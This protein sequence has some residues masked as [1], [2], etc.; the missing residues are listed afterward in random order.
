MKYLSVIL[1]LVAALTLRAEDKSYIYRMSVTN[2][3]G[4]TQEDTLVF[5]IQPT[6]TDSVDFALG[7]E[8]LPSVA[9]FGNIYG[10][11][12]IFTQ[13][14]Y[15]TE[16]SDH[17]SYKEFRYYK[18]TR[19]DSIVYNYSVYNQDLKTT[20]V[21]TAPGNEL[22]SAFITD[23]NGEMFRINMKTQNSV[24]IDLLHMLVRDYR[25]VLYFNPE[26]Y[27]STTDEADNIGLEAFYF[28]QSEGIVWNSPAPLVGITIYNSLGEIC[29]ASR[30]PNT[31]GTIDA[32]NIVQGVFFVEFAF[33]SGQKQVK[34]FIKY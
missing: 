34:K 5:G 15:E 21:W 14:W 1:L 12:K 22:D 30:N 7:E 17:W 4:I 25:I 26:Y 28:S 31:S 3:A 8:D 32:S 18:P 24:S 23:A 9:P 2:S 33:A 11:F 10:V 27:T 6:A 16:A 20:F 29:S 13:L 19:G